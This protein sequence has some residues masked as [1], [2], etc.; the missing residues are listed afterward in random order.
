MPE[1]PNQFVWHELMTSDANAAESFY[2]NVIGW[3]AKDSGMPGQSY[4]LLSAGATMVAGLMPTPPHAAGVPPNWMG[5]IG[6]ND[7]DAYAE[8][9]KAAGGSICRDPEDI[10]NIGRFS[11]AQDPHGAMF[12]LFSGSGEMPPAAAPGTPGHVGW[13]ELHAD[14]LDS[15]WAF[16][17]GLFGWTKA[18][19]VDMGPMGIYQTFA[20][21]GAPVGGMMTKM[22]EAPAPSWLYY[23]NVDAIDAAVARVT[24]FGGKIMQDPHQVPG[25]SW[26]VVALDP[27]GASFAL[28]ALKR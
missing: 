26:I 11:V 5:Y 16:Y 1:T 22:P 6:V 21:G 13:N 18:E 9:V 10:P 12:T 8:R 15:A 17:S 14:D 19:A 3:E 28:V 7:V 25:G 23:F 27:Q 2:V 4:T 24:E 20:T